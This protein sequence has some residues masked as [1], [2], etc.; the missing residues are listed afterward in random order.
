MGGSTKDALDNVQKQKYAMDDNAR[1]YKRDKIDEQTRAG[2]HTAGQNTGH[3][4]GEFEAG[5]AEVGDFAERNTRSL[6]PQGDGDGAQGSDSAEANYSSSGQTQTSSGKGK[7][8]NLKQKD[9]KSVKGASKQ[10][11]KKNK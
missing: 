8:A 10:L 5:V 2:Q 6:M 11:T 4:M 3:L 1:N 9:K 7:K